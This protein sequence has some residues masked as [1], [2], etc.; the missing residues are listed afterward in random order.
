MSD[1]KITSDPETVM[2]GKL[3]GLTATIHRYMDEA[4][5]EKA[6]KVQRRV[7]MLALRYQMALIEIKSLKLQ[8]QILQEGGSD[9][10]DDF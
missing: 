8:L 6:A 4:G 3:G 7:R 2:A 10:A 1:R 9:E 5:I